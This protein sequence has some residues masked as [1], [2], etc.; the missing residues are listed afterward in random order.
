MINIQ[1]SHA[2]NVKTSTLMVTGWWYA[3]CVIECTHIKTNISFAKNAMNAKKERERIFFIVMAVNNVQLYLNKST[4][5]ILM[6]MIY[7]V[8]PNV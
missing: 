7:I 1:V 3:A 6:N 8:A 4:V 2:N 5:N